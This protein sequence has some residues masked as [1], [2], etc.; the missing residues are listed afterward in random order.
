MLPKIL[1]TRR[2]SVLPLGLGD[3]NLCIKHMGKYLDFLTP[4]NE[5]GNYVIIMPRQGVYI[6]DKTIEPM[7]WNGTQGMEVYALFGNELALYELSVKDD[8]VSYVR[9]RA[10]EEFLRGV[11]M[12]GNAVNEILSVVDSLLRNYIRSSF[13]IYTAYL[14]LALNGMIRFPGYR[15]YVRGRVRVYGKDSLVI[16]K[17]SSGSE[18]RVSLVTTIESIDQFTKIVMDLVRASRIINDFR[19]GRIGHSVRMIL[20]AFIPNNLITLSNEDT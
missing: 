5:V 6:N 19:L 4:C 16:V 17:E 13:M 18:L 3:Y 20:D 2:H 8:K 12:S 9:Y 7:S 1:L 10:N 15:E 11:N 14:R